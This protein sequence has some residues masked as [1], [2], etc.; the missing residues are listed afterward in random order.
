MVRA[1]C[2]CGLGIVFLMI[3]PPLRGQ[4]VDMLTKGVMTFESYAPLSYVL[5]VVAVLVTFLVSLKRGSRV[6]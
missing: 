5:G 2:L 6:R 4:V 1:L 3:S